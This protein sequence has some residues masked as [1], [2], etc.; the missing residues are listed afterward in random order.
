MRVL[1]AEMMADG[2]EFGMFEETLHQPFAEPFAA[3][4]WM[5]D[6]IAQPGERGVIG[7]TASEADLLS[8]MEQAE[9]NGVAN[10]FFDDFAGTVVGPVSG[11]EHGANGIEV[12]AARVVGQQII[13]VAPFVSLLA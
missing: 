10:G 12:Q 6:D 8:L 3:V 1:G 11:M 7:N 2:L 5:H 9:A 13:A 4:I